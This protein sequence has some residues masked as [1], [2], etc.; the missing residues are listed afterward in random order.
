MTR[1]SGVDG[2][3]PFTFPFG[4]GMEMMRRFWGATDATSA[5]AAGQSGPAAA[6]ANGMPTMMAPTLDLGEIDKRIAE[7][8]AVEQWLQLN[9]NMLRATIQSLEVQRNTIATLRSFGNSIGGAT[10]R[11]EGMPAASAGK[12]TDAVAR[13]AAKAP[14]TRTEQRPIDPA[15][16]LQPDPALWWNALQEQF[17]ALASAASPPAASRK[18][19]KPRKRSPG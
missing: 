10:G 8:R 5:A 14:A 17:S 15:A 7:L 9:A 11:T 18:P 6:F 19:A 3:T 2:A 12:D 4:E 13:K 1:K 16:A